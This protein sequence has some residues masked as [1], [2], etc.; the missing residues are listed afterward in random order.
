MAIV[1]AR[2]GMI[3]PGNVIHGYDIDAWQETS[4]IL[5]RI[6]NKGNEAVTV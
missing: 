4:K 3:D 6:N 2:T 1:H 5:D